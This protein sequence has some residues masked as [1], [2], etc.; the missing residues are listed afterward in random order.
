M[1]H[2]IY[3]STVS[4]TRTEFNMIRVIAPLSIALLVTIAGCA[5]AGSKVYKP[6]SKNTVRAAFAGGV[7]YPK[8]LQAVDAPGLSSSVDRRTGQI[9]I[10]NYSNE[11][12]VEPRVWINQIY[13]LR[14][15]SLGAQ[16]YV[17]LNKGD[18]YNAVGGSLKDQ[19]VNSIKQIQLQVEQRLINVM[20]P[21]LE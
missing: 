15:R 8:D 20:G 3:L 4:L 9:T 19:P 18:F 21:M 1:R 12:Q 5:P 17:V 6:N 2:E 14:V 16:D 10:R 7:D 11:T 13:V